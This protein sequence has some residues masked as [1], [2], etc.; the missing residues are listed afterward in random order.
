MSGRYPF[1]MDGAETFAVE[2]VEFL[3]PSHPVYALRPADPLTVTFG[4]YS[5][6]ISFCYPGGEGPLGSEAGS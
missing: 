3:D 2:S 6:S 4:F 5:P 1:V